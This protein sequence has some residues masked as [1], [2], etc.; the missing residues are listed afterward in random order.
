MFERLAEAEAAIHDVPIDRIHLHEVGALDS[1]IDIVGAVF[2]MEWLG[3]DDVIG[4]A[5][6][7]GQRNGLVRAWRV[8]RCRRQP[9]R[10]FLP[11][12]RSTPEP[13]RASSSRQPA[14]C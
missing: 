12:C 1:I 9:P 5:V 13:W 11:A 3:V 6:E 14:R 10:G 8:S 4:V 7:R 2:G